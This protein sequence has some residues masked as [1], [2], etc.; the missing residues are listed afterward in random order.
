MSETA[1]PVDLL[2]ALLNETL[3]AGVRVADDGNLYLELGD[4][5]GVV[6]SPSPDGEDIVLHCALAMLGSTADAGLMTAAL[7]CNLHQ[8]QTR[9][10]AI[11]L[12]PDAQLLVFSW[13]LPTRTLDSPDDL[14]A[15]LDGFCATAGE[16]SGRLEE[17]AARV[18]DLGG[19]WADPASEAHGCRPG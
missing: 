7:A 18:A 13:R 5:Q 19:P 3:A 16:L 9:G 14:L 11:G 8:A 12:D 17:A 2:A 1:T 6:V 4:G 15:L 10:G